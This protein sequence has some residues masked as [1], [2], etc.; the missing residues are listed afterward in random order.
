[1][2]GGGQGDEDELLADEG[3]EVAA[4]EA[5]GGV[6]VG[7]AAHHAGA[8][9]ELE[10]VPEVEEEEL[11]DEPAGVDPAEDVLPAAAAAEEQLVVQD[12][13]DHGQFPGATAR[14]GPG[15]ERGPGRLVVPVSAW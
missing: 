10:V 12:G 5:A 13:T 8:E 3:D 6:G 14:P 2:D 9:V 11:G 7:D 15:C 4:G 1:E